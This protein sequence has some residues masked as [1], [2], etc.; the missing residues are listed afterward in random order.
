MSTVLNIS[1]IIRTFVIG[2]IIATYLATA[3]TASAASVSDLSAVLSRLES[4][5]QH[6]LS[7]LPNHSV[8]GVGTVVVTNDVELANA[9]KNAT[10]GETIQLAPG[11]YG[12]IFMQGGQF[13]KLNVGATSIG[14]GTPT[15]GS[16]V[17][18]E[19]QSQNN[20]AVVHSIDVRST[21][22]WHFNNLDIRPGT[23]GGANFKAVNMAGNNL[24]IENSTI[25]YGDSTGWTASDWTSKAG[26]GIYM[27]G[28]NN[29][30][31]N[32]SLHTINMGITLDQNGQ[33]SVVQ[34]NTI[35]GIAGDGGRQL[36]SGATW[37]NN[38]F[39]NFKKVDSN[40][41]DCVQSW[42]MINGKV[43][44]DG[45]IDG[46]TFRNNICI[47]TTGS[48][49]DPLYSNPQG[50]GSFDGSMQNWVVEN[51]VYISSAY[52]GLNHSGAQNMMI[53]NNTIID[54]DP[55]VNGLDTV[56]LRVSGNKSGSMPA[57]NNSF[58]DNVSNRFP[59]YGQ[60][61]AVVQNSQVVNYANYDTIF[62]DWRNG[63]VR[64]KSGQSLNGAGANLDPAT[65]GSN[66]TITNS[67]PTP[68]PTPTPTDSD[69]DGVADTVDNC[70]NVSNS[71]Q[72][73]YDN[74]R[75][76]DACDT[77]DD[78]D[79][80]ADSNELA[81]CQ[82]DPSATCGSTP[83]PTPT[84]T[85]TANS[86]VTEAMVTSVTPDGNH[87]SGLFDGCVN[88][89]ARTCYL[90]AGNV[91]RTLVIEFDLGQAYDLTAAKLYG[92]SSGNAVSKTWSL[93]YKTTSNGNY[94]NAF[95]DQNALGNQWF[96]Q[97]FNATARYVQ[98]T[99]NG[100]TGSTNALINEF[101]LAGTPNSGTTPTPTP[102]PVPTDTDSDGVADT[103]DNCPAVSNANQV[104]FDGDS[105]GDACDTDDDNDGILDTAEATGCQFNASSTCGQV[106]P[107][108]TPTTGTS[109][110]KAGARIATTDTVNVRN[111][112]LTVLGT[113]NTSAVGTVLDI[114][115]KVNGGY[116]YIP[117]DF[118]N[119]VDGWIADA[120][121][122]AYS[123]PIPTPTPTPT[124]EEPSNVTPV[125][126]GGTTE[127]NT[128]TRVLTT[129]NLNV[130]STPNG[131]KLGMQQKGAFGTITDQKRTS[132]AG[133]DWVAVNFDNSPD[134]YVADAFLTEQLTTTGGTTVN[135][136]SIRG[137]INRLLREIQRLQAILASMQG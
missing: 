43:N 26:F 114:T 83:N 56:W 100:N 102:I 135:S 76:G 88:Q 28:S 13:N 40:H 39:K 123:K 130:R 37:E 52:H 131:A 78:N 137:E 7:L 17:I 4:T 77:D 71:T 73:D 35:D 117:V 34:N 25:D 62:R 115:P 54:S 12:K 9:L 20:P 81:G 96:T 101:E 136:D 31:K 134:G 70:P 75:Q 42:G 106:S 103:V 5:L 98:L 14:G 23:S 89:S 21:D 74:D 95:T 59:A 87:I 120:F 16:K 92:Q 3:P 38:L 44:Q 112:E 84:P 68:T 93:A 107:T 67:S 91:S 6:L 111:A 113:Q 49:S 85:P 27:S 2:L 61:P 58:I 50:F 121:V 66:R 119:G 18:I 22:N 127:V 11:T 30:V 82:F 45:I 33:G 64:L 118:D 65:V 133:Y 47:D 124:P 132:V 32:N 48:H 128:S 69:N 10:G 99:V 19:S 80:I 63:D 36:Q 126:E 108:P 41:D 94:Q 129:E 72:A 110:F 97:S 57:K 86:I 24:A 46:V 55:S 51:N 122:T 53:R 90:T 8:L 105:Q 60:T 109:V 29:L 104:N 15:L 1:S 79:G 125:T 116:T